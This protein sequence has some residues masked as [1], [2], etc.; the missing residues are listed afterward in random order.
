MTYAELFWELREWIEK[1]DY[2]V[3]NM[4]IGTLMDLL[5]NVLDRSQEIFENEKID[6]DL[7]CDRYKTT[8]LLFEEKNKTTKKH[9]PFLDR[10][11]YGKKISSRKIKR[12]IKKIKKEKRE[13]NKN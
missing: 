8:H 7:L 3:F 2:D 4:D 10:I 5:E 11:K 12:N 13:E 9:L 6:W 1:A